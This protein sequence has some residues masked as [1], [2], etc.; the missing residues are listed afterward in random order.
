M[1]LRE[2]IADLPK[3]LL[4]GPLD[5]EITSVVSDSRLATPGSVFVA[6]RGAEVDGRQFIDAAV[7]AGAVAVVA[8]SPPETDAPTKITWLQ[9]ADTRLALSRMAAV[10]AGRPSSKLKLAGV[11][12]TNG[13]TTVGF[14]VHHIMR[15]VWHRAGL[16]GT[17][18]VDDGEHIGEASHT[19]PDTVALQNL[20]ARMLDNG[21]RG[22][23][24]EVSSHGI[25][26]K[27]VADVAF[28]AMVF[29][30]LTQ[31]HLDYHGTMA[32]YMAAKFAWFEAAAADPQGK[33]PVAVIN[34][35]DPV[36]AELADRI[37]GR[38]PVTRYGFGL[39]TDIRALDFRQSVRGM[40]LKLEVR[41]KQYLV[42]APLIGRFNAY[43]I[44]A[45]IGA[46]KASGISVRN[47]VAALAEAPQV[48]GRMENSGTRDGVTVYVDYAHTPDAL[49]NVCRTVKDLGP[50]RLITVFGCGGDRDRKK[51]PLMAKAAARYSDVCVITSDNPRSEKPEDIIREIEAGM[52]SAKYRSV[53][54]RAEAIRI[55]VHAAAP[56]DIVLVAGK[57]HETYQQ[58]ADGKIDF[59]DRKEV[60]RALAA[61]PDPE[62]RRKP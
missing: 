36:G 12:G 16:L 46:A 4:M 20:L 31:D 1:T 38:L 58:F 15:S 33:K 25:D 43:N 53:P 14:L 10:M 57:G 60:K 41:G 7:R 32:N 22:A 21:C 50:R 61:R 44:M 45:A 2:L 59:D 17:V 48:P 56:G 37:D 6:I 39:H 51:R 3:P 40:E 35:D 18:V 28:D 23:A 52:G 11:T 62:E 19:T 9:V 42:R 24:L 29:T 13:K 30:N 47:A 54:D 27:R 49:E 55:A 5:T 26:Q 8:D 34:V